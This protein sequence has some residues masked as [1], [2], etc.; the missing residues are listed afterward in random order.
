MLCP[1]TFGFSCLGAHQLLRKSLQIAQNSTSGLTL[2][3][4]ILGSKHASR[5]IPDVFVPNPFEPDTLF[6]QPKRV[7]RK[8]R[9]SN[10]FFIHL[11]GKF[12]RSFSTV[13]D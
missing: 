11:L 7:S 10:M 13:P 1:L 5:I 4:L 9:S 6:Q 2:G 8:G 3:R 12:S